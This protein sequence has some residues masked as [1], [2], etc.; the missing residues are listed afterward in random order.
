[1]SKS[2]LT[3]FAAAALLASGVAPPS[4]A[5]AKPA[6]KCVQTTI[7][8]VTTYFENDPSS[9][10]V[11][12]F[13]S[14]LGVASFKGQKATIVDR[15]ATAGAAITKA[16]AGDAVKLC[17]VETPKS[18]DGCD[19]NKDSRG[20]IYSAYDQ[21]LHASFSGSNANHGCGGA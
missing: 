5:L 16:R 21:R 14:N 17:L 9:G 20:R 3:I 11:I 13:A 10:S 8:R 1:M 2:I 19:P 18:G 6:P 7:A 12:I 4:P 15:F